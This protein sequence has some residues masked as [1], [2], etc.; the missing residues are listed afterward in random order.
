MEALKYTLSLAQL[1]YKVEPSAVVVVPLSASDTDLFTNVYVVPPTFLSA[2]SGGGAGAGAGAG[3]PGGS[4]LGSGGWAAAAE[5]AR[6][7]E[8]N[9]K[10]VLEGFGV[11]FGAGTS[12]TFNPNSSQLIV[13]QTQDQMELVE[14]VIDSIRG[15]RTSRSS[16][17]RSLLRWPGK[18]EMNLDSTGSWDL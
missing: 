15:V 12:A 10:E 1:K 5:R 8:R 2:G 9:A 13:K 14:A 7:S 3:G 11:V 16:W 6:L 4:F 18:S 17:R